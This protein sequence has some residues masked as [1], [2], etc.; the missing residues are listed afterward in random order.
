ML[1]NEHCGVEVWYIEMRIR[2]TSQ[3]VQP[4]AANDR[5]TLAV[6]LEDGTLTK[7]RQEAWEAQRRDF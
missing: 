1:G 5:L 6:G 3:E 2:Q 7:A 4:P